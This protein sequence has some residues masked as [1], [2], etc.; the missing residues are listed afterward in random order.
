MTPW[1]RMAMAGVIL[2]ALAAC[3]GPEAELAREQSAQSHYDIGLGALAENNLSKAINEFRIAVEENPRNARNHHALGN[4]LLRNQQLDEAIQALRRA[5]ELQ[6]RLSDAFNDLAA[7]YIRKQMWDLAIDAF[8]RALANPQYLNPDRAYLN[9]GNIYYIRGQYEQAAEEF[10][11]LL[12]V[13]PQSPDGHFFLG[14]TLLAQGKLEEA[15]E[16]LEQAIKLEGTIPIFHFEMGVTLLRMGRRAE[17]RESFRKAVDINPAGPEAQE[18][19]R[20]LRELN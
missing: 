12:D 10:R 18:A 2:A 14:R 5:V 19:R 13:V 3:T 11:R 1:A 15:R 4:A 17:A 6:P 20:Y 9:L 8:R 7:A 16:K